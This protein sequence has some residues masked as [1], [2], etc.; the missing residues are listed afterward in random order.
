MLRLTHLPPFRT[1]TSAQTRRLLSVCEA[2]EYEV[3]EVVCDTGTD[4]TE[5]FILF[6]GELSV[7]TESGIPIATLTPVTIVGEM[8][9]ITG[10]Q[11][12]ATVRTVKPSEAFVINKQEF[13]QLVQ[14]NEKVGLEV[15][16]NMAQSL[17][18]KIVNDNIRLRD[19][20]I[21]KRSYESSCEQKLEVLKGL[22]VERGMSEQEIEAEMAKRSG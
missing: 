4:S 19:Y 22:L 3:G 8:G 15:Y 6:S 2:R 1:L 7:G 18:Y 10:Q 12:S 21:E 20:F 17:C 11:R 9:I 14:E 5:M 13:E 16:R